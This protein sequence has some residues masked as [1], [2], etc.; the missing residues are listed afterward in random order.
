MT[1]PLPEA[2]EGKYQVLRKVGEGGMGAIYQVRHRLLVKFRVCILDVASLAE[3]HDSGIVP[4]LGSQLDELVIGYLGNVGLRSKACGKILLSALDL[5]QHPQRTCAVDLFR[6]RDR[7]K[8]LADL[9]V[10]LF[11]GFI[12]EHLQAQCGFSFADVC[13][14][15]CV[16][17]LVHLHTPA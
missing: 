3:D 16:F 2:I 14:I 12:S 4:L 8:K 15:Q 17:D 7:S 13:L 9:N 1:A 6:T 11:I 10:P 5:L